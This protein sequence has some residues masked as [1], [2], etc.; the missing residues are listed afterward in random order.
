MCANVCEL[1]SFLFIVFGVGVITLSDPSDPNTRL[2]RQKDKIQKILKWK[3]FKW[4]E[5]RYAIT[6]VL[7]SIGGVLGIVSMALTW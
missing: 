4:L 2:A 3:W 6:Y 5:K 1:I 7:L